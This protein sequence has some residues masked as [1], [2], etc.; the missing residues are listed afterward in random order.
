MNRNATE[1][2]K[3]AVWS[4]LTGRGGLLNF[5]AKFPEKPL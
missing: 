4:G 1:T 5:R 2:M 3:D